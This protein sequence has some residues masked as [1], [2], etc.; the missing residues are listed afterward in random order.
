MATKQPGIIWKDRKHTGFI[1][2][3]FTKYYIEDGRLMLQSGIL[4][5]VLDETLLYRI[6]DITMIQTLGGKFFGTGTL[7]LKT[8]VDHTPE[9]ILKN[10]KNPRKTRKLISELVEE[11]RRTGNVIGKEFYGTDPDRMHEMHHHMEDH[12][13]AEELHDDVCPE[14]GHHES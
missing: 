5:T 10:I 2:S 13:H 1:P 14:C 9:V 7:I 6:V 11:S 12:C 3:P 8:K 4:K